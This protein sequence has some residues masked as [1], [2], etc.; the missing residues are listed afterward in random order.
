[1]NHLFE[2]LSKEMMVTLVAAMPLVEL[3]GAIPLGVSLGMSPLHATVLS[4]MGSMIP[5]PFLLFFLKP[6]FAKM[7]KHPY[8]KRFADWLTHRTLKKTKNVQKYSALGLMLFVAVPLPT[9]GVWTGSMAAALLNI[10]FRYS[11]I[12]ILLGNCIAAF[13]VMTLSDVV[14]NL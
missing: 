2:I 8:W 9:T 7:K 11:F 4:L 12:S 14:V 6:I 1:M 5:V 3:R 10:P 13:I